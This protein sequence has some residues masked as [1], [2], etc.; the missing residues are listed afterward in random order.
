MKTIFLHIGTHKT[1]STAIQRFLAR[2]GEALSQQ[3]VLYPR[4]GCPNTDWS[5]QYGQHKLHWSLVGKRGISDDHVWHD[6]QREIEACSAER[7]L[8]SIEGFDHIRT[9]KIE[10]V[11]EYLRPH[12]VRVLVYLRPPVQ[13]LRSVYKQRVKGGKYGGSFVRFVK[14][15][16][17]RCNYLDLVSRWKQFDEVESVD[18]RLFDKVKNDPGLEQSFANAVGIDFEKVQEFTGPPVNLSP[19]DDRVQIARWINAAAGFGKK[20]KAWQ[21]LTSRARD[22]VLGPRWPGTWL[23]T[24]MQPFL[25]S[26]L[27]TSQ[28]VEV[29]R[30]ELEDA[31]RHF[32][33]KYVD[34]DDRHYLSL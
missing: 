19:S 26:S 10:R 25:R 29:L 34:P 31:H 20:W 8:L 23:A 1:G 12:P 2:A 28:A 14:E 27:V 11:L 22:N 24:V 33:N 18:I 21:A 3:G 13:F 4:A 16:T 7:I 5:D 32:L 6:L 17:P 30:E 15:M 9:Q